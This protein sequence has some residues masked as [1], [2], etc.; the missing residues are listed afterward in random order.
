MQTC[1]SIWWRFLVSDRCLCTTHASPNSLNWWPG[2]KSFQIILPGDSMFFHTIAR[3]VGGSS[4]IQSCGHTQQ[5]LEVC[6]SWYDYQS[7]G[8]CNGLCR[9]KHLHHGRIPKGWGGVFFQIITLCSLL[10]HSAGR[11]L[12]VPWWI[13][14]FSWVQPLGSPVSFI[15]V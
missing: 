11:V 13:L 8:Y 12:L 14:P 1:R 7:H 5:V 10:S 6:P 4:S 3:N 2:A 15:P 9:C